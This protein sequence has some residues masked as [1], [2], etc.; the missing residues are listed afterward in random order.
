MAT[1]SDIRTT[2]EAKMKK[3]MDVLRADLA[4]LRAGRASSALLEK[5]TVDYYGTPT[6]ITQVA[7]VSVPEPR[8]IVIQ[9]WEKNLMKDIEKAIMKSD[10]GLMPN[11]DGVVIRLSIPQMTEQRRQELVKV[12]HKKT[13]DCRVAVRNVRRDANDVIKKIEKDKEVSEDEAKKAQEDIQK[14]TDKIIKDIDLVMSAKE[15]EI[16]EV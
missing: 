1:I 16:M 5:V 11:N 12:V 13:E 8:M 10:L 7:N 14:L 6:P 3:A 9:P 2:H 15:K 4:S